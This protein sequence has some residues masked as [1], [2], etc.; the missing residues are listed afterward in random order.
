MHDS[1][2]DKLEFLNDNEKFSYLFNEIKE[3]FFKEFDEP[4]LEGEYIQ[5]LSSAKQEFEGWLTNVGL[6]VL[7]FF[8]TSLIQIKLRGEVTVFETILSSV[9]LFLLLVSIS[10]GFYSK[11][12][13]YVFKTGNMVLSNKDLVGYF[14]GLSV[15]RLLMSLLADGINPKD[16]FDNL[17]KIQQDTL[18][19]SSELLG[20]PPEDCLKSDDVNSDYKAKLSELTRTFKEFFDSWLL[21]GNS[22]SKGYDAYLVYRFMISFL[23]ILLQSFSLLIGIFA[24]VI[25]MLSFVLGATSLLFDILCALL[26]L[27]FIVIIFIFAKGLFSIRSNLYDLLLGNPYDKR[28]LEK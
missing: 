5:K 28:P 19:S 23:G 14:L 27:A 3:G 8:V 25:F 17:F 9:S 18:I 22:N 2:S 15:T 7:G 11:I 13:A 12:T 6:A 1:D 21:S 4:N 26:V 20:Q 24:A 16:Y 10:I